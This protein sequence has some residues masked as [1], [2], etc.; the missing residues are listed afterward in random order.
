MSNDTRPEIRFPGFTEDWEERK[1][2]DMMDVTSVKRIHQSDWTNSGIRFLRARDIVSAAKNEEPSDYL[3][4]SEEKYNEYSK[5][6]GKV[7]QGDLLVTG[8]GSIGVPLLITDDNPIYF[9]D[10]NIIWFKNEHKIDGNFFYYSFINNKIQKYIRDVAGIGTVGTYTI[11]SGKKTPISLPTYD[12]QI[13]IGSFFKQ[14]DHTIA[15]HQRKLDLLKETKKGFL[16]KMFPKNGAKVPEIRFPGFTKDWEERKLGDVFSERSERSSE[17]ELI[18]VTINSGVI[19]AS[20]LDRKDNSSDNKSNYK[21]VEVGDIAYNS[22]RMWQGA[23]GYSS[24][25]GILSPAYTVI[26]PKEGTDSKFFAY[27]FKRYDMI[28]TFKRNS[29]GL[30][31]DTWNLKFPTLKLV[32]IMVP[33]IEEQKQ[34][35]AFFERL[36]NTIALHE[37]ELDVLKETKK[38]FLQKMLV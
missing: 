35:A 33:S 8:V 16:Q 31:S 1:L 24:Y 10:G 37:R 20:E 23:S 18:S 12:E 30:T 17:G 21:K 15:L 28:Q 38:G 5:I 11:D 36:D 9:K 32:K 4:I 6:S 27:D 13:K 3:Y 14:L 29:Q 7:S 22:M 34:I 2:G 26:I 19:K 25:E